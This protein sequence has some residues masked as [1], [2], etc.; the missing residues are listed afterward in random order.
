MFSRKSIA[1]DRASTDRHPVS[2]RKHGTC[3][4]VN[5]LGRPRCL[6]KAQRNHFSCE[7]FN[8]G[9]RQSW[10][11]R[12]RIREIANISFMS[13]WE[14]TSLEQKVEKLLKQALGQLDFSPSQPLSQ[15]THRS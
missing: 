3:S 11:T 1:N 9:S 7:S 14:K 10:L 13:Q 12:S 4:S 8:F 15:P 6:L 5:M 2:S